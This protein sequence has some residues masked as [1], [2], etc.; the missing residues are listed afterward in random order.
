[1]M[2]SYRDFDTHSLSS[3]LEH[4]DI[5]PEPDIAPPDEFTHGGFH[6]GDKVSYFPHQGCNKLSIQKGIVKSLNEHDNTIAFVVYHCADDWDNYHAYTGA[7][8][9][10]KDLKLGW[11]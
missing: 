8:T 4:I 7:S 5:E 1:M 9:K 10:I 2:S 3:R 6:P 11:I